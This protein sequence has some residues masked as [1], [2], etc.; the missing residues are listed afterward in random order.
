MKPIK[1]FPGYYIT[2]RGEVYCDLPRANQKPPQ[3]P[4]RVS[5]WDRFGYNTVSLR[6]N[7]KSY[8]KFVHRLVL[9]AFAGDCP[10]GQQCRHLNG[11]RKD[12]RLENLK[13]GTR[14]E[15]QMDRVKHGTDNRGEKHGNS[16]LT[17]DVVLEIRRL[18]EQNKFRKREVGGNY[19]KIA[20]KFN[21]AASTVGQIVRRKSWSWIK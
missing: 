20:K 7:K 10:D 9:E 17:K 16:K 12:N 4:R 6:K 2:R 3:R 14:S 15:N 1:D 5:L 18:G 19:K 13:W 11:N 21:I 8:K